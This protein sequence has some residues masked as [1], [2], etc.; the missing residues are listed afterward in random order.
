MRFFVVGE[1]IL[2]SVFIERRTCLPS[3]KG[4]VLSLGQAE[5]TMVGIEIDR[6]TI[7][8]AT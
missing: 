7:L 6:S 3:K 8:K 2:C 5:P 4:E 1:L